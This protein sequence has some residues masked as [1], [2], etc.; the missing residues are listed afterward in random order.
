MGISIPDWQNPV[1]FIVIVL[2]LTRPVSPK[3]SNSTMSMFV[4]AYLRASTS[5]QDA[6]R[7]RDMLDCFAREHNVII[8]NYYAENESGARLERPELFRLLN[9]SRPSYVLHILFYG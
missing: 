5:E 3:N 1:L 6:Q 4:R 9:D 7:A 8:C 2:I